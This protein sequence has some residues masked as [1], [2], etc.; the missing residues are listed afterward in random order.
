M[1][2]KSRMGPAVAIVLAVTLTGCRVE[3]DL[4]IAVRRDGGGVVELATFADADALARAEAAGADPLALVV[5][6][7]RG[8]EGWTLEDTTGPRGGRTVR[9]RT[10]AA[11]AA[12]LNA[13]L[14]DVAEALAAPEVRLLEGL[15]VQ[16]EDERLLLDGGATMVPSEAVAD[17]GVTQEE[18]VELARDA[19]AWT[20]SAELPGDVLSSN[21]DEEMGGRL[22]WRVD[23]GEEVDI[24]AEGTR[25][26]P[27]S[28]VQLLLAAA[29]SGLFALAA[30]VLWLRHRR[31]LHARMFARR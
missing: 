7:S 14:D 12:A 8:L 9:L 11:D 18:A 19:F 17:Y 28:V 6:A 31:R 5:D 10:V 23:A 25:P 30:L 29:T 15:A 4:D 26:P 1:V 21:A 13:V 27:Y 3:L 16:V 20:V 22:V 24:A 2:L